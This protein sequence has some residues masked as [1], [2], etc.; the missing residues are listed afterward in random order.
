VVCDAEPL[1]R[2]QSQQTRKYGIQ[3]AVR[4]QN[5]NTG[6]AVKLSAKSE[7]CKCDGKCEIKD[8]ACDCHNYAPA[9]SKSLNLVKCSSLYNKNPIFEP[10]KTDLPLSQ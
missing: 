5:G 2:R 1:N 8:C 6:T 3:K 10:R 7:V 9:A 4:N